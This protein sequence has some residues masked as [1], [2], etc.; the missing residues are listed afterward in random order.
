MQAKVRRRLLRALT[1]R[2]VL[3]PEDA[4]TMASWEH[5]G[6]FSLDASVR[7][8]GADR[9]G[10]ERLLRYCARPAFALER[11][12][13]EEARGEEEELLRRAAR[14]AWA[15]LIA[16]IYEAF[17]LVCPRCGS[18]MRII[19]F[20]TDAGAVRDILTHLGE[21]TSPPRLM[22]ARAPPLW[23][24]QGATTGEPE[25]QPQPVPEYE[26]DQRIAW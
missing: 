13:E 25:P 11:W 19:A 5:G 23:E 6:G 2:G 21:P 3:E 15:L 12:R 26:F 7:V 14:Y 9:E 20:I 8:E 10:L 17:P 18:E 22:P 4:E 1:R 24:M 16:R